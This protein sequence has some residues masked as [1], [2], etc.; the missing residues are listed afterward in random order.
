VHKILRCNNLKEKRLKKEKEK[1]LSF[2]WAVGRSGPAGRRARA[3]A[4][5]RRPSCGPRRETA[6]AREGDGVSAGP[7]R[8]RERKG[9][10]TAPAVDGGVNRPSAGE[11]PAADGL[12]GDSPLVGSAAIRRR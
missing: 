6:R 9:R 7:T 2:W 10:G 12:G 8:Q 11:N 1:E 4:R 3:N 5:L